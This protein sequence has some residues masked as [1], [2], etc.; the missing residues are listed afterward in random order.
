ML[1]LGEKQTFV[2]AVRADFF[3]QGRRECCELVF[4]DGR[5]L[6]C[7]PDHQIMTTTGWRRADLLVPNESKVVLGLD[8]PHYDPTADRREHVAAFQL[9]I[10]G[11]RSLCLYC[12]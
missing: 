3:V 7:T 1:A 4:S 9:T 10:N 12:P 6:V 5:T 8:G 2:P 11:V